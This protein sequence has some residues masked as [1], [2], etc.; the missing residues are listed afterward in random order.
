MIM[1][2]IN[3]HSKLKIQNYSIMQL[4]IAIYLAINYISVM[5]AAKEKPSVDLIVG[6]WKFDDG[7]ILHIKDCLKSQGL[8]GFIFGIDPNIPDILNPLPIHRTKLLCGMQLAT[9][10]KQING[11]WRAG[12]FYDPTDGTIKQ[13]EIV[14]N[15][16]GLVLKTIRNSDGR[17]EKIDLKPA[18][19]ADLKCIKN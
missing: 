1:T 3:E 4:V 18:S 16:K 19:N 8:C 5:A 17:V 15:G 9:I 6:S 12:K 2:E 14:V 11:Q 13:M 7:A 10:D